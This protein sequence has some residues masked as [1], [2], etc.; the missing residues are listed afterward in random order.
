MGYKLQIQKS[1]VHKYQ[2]LIFTDR[3]WLFYQLAD[4]RTQPLSEHT[5]DVLLGR[6][7]WNQNH[8]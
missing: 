4:F 3:G 7:P 6:V 8:Y 1:P 5:P 2:K